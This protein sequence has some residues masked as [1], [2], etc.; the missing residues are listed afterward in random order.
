MMKSKVHKI[1]GINAG[2]SGEYFV[3]AELSKRGH[4]ASITLRNTRGIDILASNEDATKTVSIQVKTRQGRGRSWV[5]NQKA[6]DYHSPSL[7]YVFVNL[8]G[9]DER[10]EF[11]IVPSKLAADFVW[12]DHK[13]WLATPGRQG[14]K[15]NDTPMRQFHDEAEEFLERWDLLGLDD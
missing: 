9:I 3:A 2:V 1:S 10:A 11:F 7:F 13:M 5:L 4:I 6:E 14:Q 15:H 12:K 8:R